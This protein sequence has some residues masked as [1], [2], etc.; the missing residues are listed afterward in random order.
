MISK[1]TAK[2]F[3]QIKNLWLNCFE[4]ET[5]NSTDFYFDHLY[6]PKNTYI[7]KKGDTVLSVLQAKPMQLYMQNQIIPTHFIVGVCTETNY[8]HNGFM[9]RLME[10]TLEDLKDDPMIILQ[11]YNWNLYLPFGFE[12]YYYHHLI[13]ITM[14]HQKGDKTNCHLDFHFKEDQLLDSYNQYIQET[15][16][17]R[18]RDIN[19]YRDYFIPYH[20][21]ENHKIALVKVDEKIIGY[22]VYEDASENIIILEHTTNEGYIREIFSRFNKPI[23]L[24][25]KYLFDPEKEDY[26]VKNMA[27]RFQDKHLKELFKQ[28]IPY[29]NEIL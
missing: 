8:R 29:I 21:N 4:D 18:V 2:D 25:T 7:L 9:K 1:A 22:L 27:I 28:G 17:A 20:Q 5:R 16:G 11:A 6:D 10:R 12:N 26:K 23:L 13:L 15:L 19:Y 24:R 3:D 14:E